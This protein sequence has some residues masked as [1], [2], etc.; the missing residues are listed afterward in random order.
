[1]FN[2][3]KFQE[4]LKKTK[5]PEHMIRRGLVGLGE[6]LQPIEDLFNQMKPPEN[7]WTDEQIH[8][9]LEIL[10]H[11][12]SNNDPG[13]Y[14]IGEREARIS[15]PMLYNLSGGF[16]HGIGRSGDIKASQP[17]ATGASIMNKL[18]DSMVTFFLKDMGLENIS[19]SIVVPLSTGMS[20]MLTLR[21]LYSVL[22]NEKSG[23]EN[24]E[25][26]K[27]HKIIFPRMDH[28]SPIKGIEL[29]GFERIS[30]ETQLG[31]KY[32][33]YLSN[34]EKDDKIENSEHKRNLYGN[35]KKKIQFIETHGLDAVYVPV[36][37]IEKAVDDETLAI[38]STTS[39][40]PPRA[41]DNIKEIAKLAQKHEIIHVINNAYGVQSPMM[42]KMIR[43]AIDAGRVDAIV[44]ST[45]K[46]FLTPIGGAII[47]S[48]SQ[49]NLQYIAQAYAGRGSSS[50]ILQLFVSMLSMGMSGYRK[51]VESQQK[52]RKL[53]EIE[54]KKLATKIGEKV[55]DVNNPIACMITL[56]SLNSKQI[57]KLGGH[58]YNLRVTGPRVVNPETKKFGPS[59]KNY[60]YPYLV[61]NSA[62]GSRKEDI[63]GAIEQ[64]KKAFKQI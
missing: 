42:M 12:D 52:N 11:M 28:K 14:R 27:K 54:L 23:T 57:E 16:I 39:F 56:Q 8:F 10:A 2:F 7:G 46:N 55:L 24:L 20:I 26:G 47:S 15:T 19:G 51:L 50:P 1:M 13:A 34:L 5:V 30:I 9:L 45:D 21:G 25:I 4:I 37:D 61:M 29:S 38:L 6:F 43:G 49:E 48:P 41:P 36:E 53:L 3:D 32:W 60:P 31:K 22:K 33:E 35:I 44:Q 64:L 18:S 63:L 17:K 40:F 62:I 59:V 58:L